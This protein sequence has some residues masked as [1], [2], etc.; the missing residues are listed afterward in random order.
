MWSKN[1]AIITFSNISPHT[2][3]R[4]CTGACMEASSRGRTS[5]TDGF[6]LC[7]L[8]ARDA[9]CLGGSL[10]LHLLATALEGTA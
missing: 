2:L 3:V 5:C 7:Y 9:K 8:L 6:L 10:L 1:C 4:R